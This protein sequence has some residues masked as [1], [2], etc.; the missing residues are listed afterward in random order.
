MVIQLAFLLTS[1]PRVVLDIYRALQL[2]DVPQ[3]RIECTVYTAPPRCAHHIRESL[4]RRAEIGSTSTFRNGARRRGIGTTIRTDSADIWII[5]ARRWQDSWHS[6]D[7]RAPAARPLS[8]TTPS[9][10]SYA[11]GEDRISTRDRHTA[12]R[13]APVDS[14]IAEYSGAHFA[15]DYVSAPLLLLT[16][17]REVW[18]LRVC[19]TFE[20]IVD[21]AVLKG[22]HFEVYFVNRL[23]C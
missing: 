1:I 23:L 6:S 4:P 11:R 13:G 3:M 10:T 22:P 9:Q 5:L 7:P 20:V 18:S 17:P 2:F 21:S 8:C 12:T 16:L 15:V 19:D 14:R